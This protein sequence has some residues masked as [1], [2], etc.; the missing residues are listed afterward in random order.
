MSD[1]R[2][3]LFRGSRLN[4]DGTGRF[5]IRALAG[6]NLIGPGAGSV[7]FQP[8]TIAVSPGA[9]LTFQGFMNTASNFPNDQLYF[10]GT[11]TSFDVNGGRL[12]LDRTR[13]VA[14]HGTATFR[15]GAELSTTGSEFSGGSF[16]SLSFESGSRLTMGHIT[17]V[18][19]SDLYL[20]GDFVGNLQGNA[21][22][23][24]KYTDVFGNA[25]INGPSLPGRR[26]A[27]ELNVKS[28]FLGAQS[29]LKITGVTGVNI[30]QALLL[31]G[32][33]MNLTESSMVSYGIDLRGGRFEIGEGAHLTMTSLSQDNNRGGRNSLVGSAAGSELVIKPGNGVLSNGSLVINP[34]AQLAI[35]DSMLSVRN[36]GTISVLGYLAGS[37]SVRGS[38]SVSIGTNGL[39]MP[40][41]G[42]AIHFDNRLDL[43]TLARVV[44]QLDRGS[45]PTR[46]LVTYGPRDVNYA[47]VAAPTIEVR[48]TGSLTADALAGR[49]VTVIAAQAP[50]AAGTLVTNGRSPN[51][52][53]VNMPALLSY[54]IGDTG[55]N[56]RP[57]V[58]LFMDRRPIGEI[59]RNPALINRNRQGAANLL[60]S[61]AAFSPA[62]T[63]T[64]NTVTNEQLAGPTDR[65][66]GGYMD[67]IHAEP[68]SS[69]ITVNLEMIANTRNLVFMR[70]ADADPRGERVWLDASESRGRIRGQDGLGSFGYSLSNVTIGK[71]LGQW[72][73][74]T[75]GGYLAYGQAR[76]TEQDIV[77]QQ[78][79]GQT[80]SGGVYAQW[81]QPGRETR[82][83]LGYGH[84]STSATRYYSYGDVSE[85]FKATYDSRNLHLGFRTSVDWIDR[86]G[87]DL[88]PEVGGSVTTYRQ[89]GFAEQGSATYGLAVASATA[90]ATIA[91]VGLNARM[92]RIWQD[93][94][95]RPAGFMR[96]EYDFARSRQ[97]GVNAALQVNPGVSETFVGQ[98]RGPVTAT[99]GIGL[100]SDASGAWQFGG[101]LAMALHTHGTAWGAGLRVR[102]LW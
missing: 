17:E 25:V 73:G 26:E 89:S 71:D 75:W 37:G 21:V 79:S 101:G 4:V 44:V 100:I 27:S 28:L 57:D 93:V 59:A 8:A 87:Y 84:G 29:S 24:A 45:L 2:L 15:N 68:Y 49:S 52:A 92:P 34:A 96:V 69:F 41:A 67:Q 70:A 94:P 10:A 83:Q 38:G 55:T 72:L 60:V 31:S 98:G 11:G 65:K 18:S 80:W 9:S 19:T 32:S 42:Q 30:N 13:L 36:D 40:V 85:T 86:A 81:R 53:A 23:N 95:V 97:H 78:L 12:N 102:Y 51:V 74:A 88:R 48:G 20:R 14:D 1:A 90:N 50:G 33:T 56:G 5:T 62:I 7:I 35:D 64:L 63:Q 76:M 46:P 61:A 58:T 47:G 77:S 99:V 6:D 39:L 91:H 82:V 3:T 43:G 16:K 54:S 66:L 22:L